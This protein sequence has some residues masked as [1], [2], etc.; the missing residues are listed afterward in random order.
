MFYD[1]PSQFFNPSIRCL[2]L[3]IQFRTKLGKRHHGTSSMREIRRNHVQ[4]LTNER[5]KLA[6][7]D[8]K[9]I[10][11]AKM[12][13]VSNV[14]PQITQDALD[15]LI[16]YIHGPLTSS[17]KLVKDR[18]TRRHRGYGYI[19]FSTPEIATRTLLSLNGARLGNRQITL[20]EVLTSLYQRRK[21]P[22]I[23]QAAKRIIQKVHSKPP[24]EGG[25]DKYEVAF[26]P[27]DR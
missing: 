7:G 22:S 16:H 4:E 12:L 24:D 21:M 18:Y 13:F 27:I 11:D 14:D 2:E 3:G 10:E 19:R 15:Y 17:T 20:S 6:K 9:V 5:C 8:N 1:N 26:L 25:V 23:L